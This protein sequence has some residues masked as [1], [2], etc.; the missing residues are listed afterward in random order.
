MSEKAELL[1]E[2]ALAKR[3]HELYESC[4]PDHGYETRKESSVP[5]D[6]VPEKNKALMIYVCSIISK[7][8]HLPESV[9]KVLEAVTILE[10]THRAG[11][12]I[13]CH[14]DGKN[15]CHVCVAIRNH[16]GRK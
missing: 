7:E 13:Q 11:F 5:W 1:P 10:S 14:H 6:K 3:F 9:E 12:S 15:E 8:R 2:E 4:A 16:E